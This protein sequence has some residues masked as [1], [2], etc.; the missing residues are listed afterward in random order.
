M[1]RRSIPILLVLVVALGCS[2]DPD[3]SPLERIGSPLPEMLDR[4]ENWWMATRAFYLA[5]DRV[6]EA[7]LEESVASFSGIHSRY[8]HW[9]AGNAASVDWLMETLRGYGAP[10]EAD[11]FRFHRTR[12]IDTANVI[13]E[14]PGRNNPEEVV[15]VGAHWDSIDYPESFQDSSVRAPGTID[16]ATGVAALVELARILGEFTLDRT[17][18]IVFFASEEIGMHGSRRERDRWRPGETTDSL[19]CMVNV[20]MLGWD[21]DRPD[22]SLICNALSAPLAG[23]LLPLVHEATQFIVVDTLLKSAAS[24]G[25][26]SDHLQFWY[27]GMPAIWLHE[28]PDDL[29]PYANTDADSLPELDAAFLADGT[30]ALVAAVLRLAGPISD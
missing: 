30:R 1:I 14:F 8:M 28:G 9:D 25:G 27:Y 2:I 20:D 22:A 18:R 26:S 17:V 11:S 16:N 7:R 5:I 10:A 23:A 3:H 15:V 21:Q 4:D 29:F 6:S 13:S 24:P 12:W 19:V